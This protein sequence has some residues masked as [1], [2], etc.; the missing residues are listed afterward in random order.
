MTSKKLFKLV[1][2]GF[3]L[4]FVS[5][6]TLTVNTDLHLEG[7]MVGTGGFSK[8]GAAVLYLD[9]TNAYT[10][11]TTIGAN[12]TVSVGA[13]SSLGS[14]ATVEIDGGS[15]LDVTAPPSFNLGAG[16]TVIGNGSILG[17]A[18]NFGSGST[19]SVG[20]TGGTSTLNIF[21]NLILQPG[22]TNMVD[23]NK[24]TTVANDKV[25]GLNSVT[26]GGTLVINYLGNSL[27]PG[28]AIQL[29]AATT[30]S[31]SFA[32]IVPATPGSGLKWDTST[33][34]TDGT[35]RVVAVATPHIGTTTISGTN[36]V[37]SGSGGTAGVGYT[38]L[39]QTNLAQ[40]LN[41]WSIIGTGLFDNSGNFS[42]TNGITPGVPTSF[43]LIRMS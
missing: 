16:Q 15:T 17:G 2:R 39:G 21:G 33:L 18:I 30:Y 40:P 29:F 43:Y 11:N 32:S 6:N 14:S 13:N 3:T 19:L 31:G 34:T 1:K 22:S 12:S 38:V 37:L 9:G 26:I 28:D 8:I 20:F 25:S 24:T 27:A 35:L 42:F 23:V 5:N 7:P 36:V 41:N 10:G 4:I